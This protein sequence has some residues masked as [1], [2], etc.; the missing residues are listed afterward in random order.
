MKKINKTNRL[1]FINAMSTFIET[2]LKGTKTTDFNDGI[3]RYVID[4]IAGNLALKICTDESYTYTIFAVFQNY[5][6]AKSKIKFGIVS[7]PKYNFH[8]GGE[9]VDNVIDQAKCFFK[10]TQIEIN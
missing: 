4:T 8:S 7:N 5:E 1:K 9:D 2:E 10:D 6:L 3:K